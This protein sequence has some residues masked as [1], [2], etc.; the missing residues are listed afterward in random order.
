MTPSSSLSKCSHRCFSQNKRNF[1]IFIK[2]QQESKQ[3]LSLFGKGLEK[4]IFI[5]SFIWE[6]VKP[7]IGSCSDTISNEKIGVVSDKNDGLSNAGIQFVS[8]KA[9][10]RIIF[11]VWSATAFIVRL[12]W[13]FLFKSFFLSIGFIIWLCD[14]ALQRQ[15]FRLIKFIRNNNKKSL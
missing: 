15:R 6:F 8:S 3:I 14:K 10:S 13:F 4:R 5:V 2:S 9:E 1:S 12:D 11:T 7:L